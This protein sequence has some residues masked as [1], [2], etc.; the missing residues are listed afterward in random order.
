MACTVPVGTEADRESRREYPIRATKPGGCDS[1]QSTKVRTETEPLH[2]AQSEGKQVRTRKKKQKHM[3]H[4]DLVPRIQWGS[5]W[6]T[7]TVK[8][9]RK[10]LAKRLGKKV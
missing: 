10:H 6:V 7:V 9:P 4:G 8:I 2:V 5:E 3:K 1:V